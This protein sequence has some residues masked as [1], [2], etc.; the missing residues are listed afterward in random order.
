MSAYH[1]KQ[2]L[3]GEIRCAAMKPLPVS[4]SDRLL[5][6]AGVGGTRDAQACF[7]RGSSDRS[8]NVAFIGQLTTGDASS[9]WLA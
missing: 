7:Y 3:S 9:G 4:Q 8:N 1:P 6:L 5:Y 2:T